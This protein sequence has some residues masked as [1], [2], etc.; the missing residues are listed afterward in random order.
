MNG[1]RIQLL[2]ADIT[3]AVDIIHYRACEMWGCGAVTADW[4]EGLFVRLAKEDL[5]KCENWRGAL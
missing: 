2:K 3:T 4:R 5:T 1:I